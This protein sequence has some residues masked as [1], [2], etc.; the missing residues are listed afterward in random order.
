MDR[1]QEPEEE[2]F[3]TLSLDDGKEL[4]C[5]VLTILEA[6][7]QDYIVLYPLDSSYQEAEGEVFIYRYFES[8]NGEV[9]LQNIETDEEF[10]LVSEAFDEY[11]DS[12]EYDE[13]VD[14]EE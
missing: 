5:Q 9:D 2:G 10:E 4:E 3:I 1:Q 8:A 11:L 7:Q 12:C 6:N 13:L 14:E